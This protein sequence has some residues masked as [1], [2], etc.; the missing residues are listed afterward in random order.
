MTTIIHRYLGLPDRPLEYQDIVDAISAGIRESEELDWKANLP[1]EPSK[2]EFAKDVTAFANASGGILVYGVADNGHVKGLPPTELPGMIE[3]LRQQLASRVRPHLNNIQYKIIDGPET[4][5]IVTV[6]RSAAAPHH[7]YEE[8]TRANRK[9]TS[10]VPERVGDQTEWMDERQLAEAYR[11]RFVLVDDRQ[12]RV[13]ELAEVVKDQLKPHYA[14]HAWV[15][16]SATPVVVEL[17][18]NRVER[19]EVLGLT[20]EALRRAS[21]ILNGHYG[22]GK[23]LKAL[24][25]TFPNPRT[26]LRRWVASNVAS[27]ADRNGARPT[28]LEIHHDGSNGA[29]GELLLAAQARCIAGGGPCRRT[30]S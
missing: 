11:R 26:G 13:E 23:V 7:V 30:T 17:A 27:K 18:D 3:K 8:T 20:E 9:R 25:Q 15:I 2:N 16:F 28:H 14:A 24:I 6:N 19:H 5:L 12:R 21:Q 29:L 4:L 10:S 1:D 22:R